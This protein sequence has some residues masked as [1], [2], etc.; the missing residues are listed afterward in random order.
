MCCKREP[1][2]AFVVRNGTVEAALVT[3]G[4]VAEYL[5]ERSV[6]HVTLRRASDVTIAA[7]YLPDDVIV[8]DVEFSCQAVAHEW[9]TTVLGNPKRVEDNTYYYC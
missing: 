1:R 2:V 4:D 7:F 6:R 8:D 3:T 5:Q 9:I